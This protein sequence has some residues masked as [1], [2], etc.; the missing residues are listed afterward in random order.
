MAPLMTEQIV[1]PWVLSHV[2]ISGTA[3][4][5]SHMEILPLK[6]GLHSLNPSIIR[7]WA[8]TTPRVSLFCT[9]GSASASEAI[10]PAVWVLSHKLRASACTYWVLHIPLPILVYCEQFSV[11]CSPSALRRALK[12]M[13]TQ[14]P[15]SYRVPAMPH[16]LLK[17]PM[18]SLHWVCRKARLLSESERF[19]LPLWLP[20]LQL[21]LLI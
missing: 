19:R 1:P 3:C 8:C 18:T 17:A 10:F 16:S 9:V 11:K 13:A 14:L 2:G 21:Y 15:V 20:M 6:K 7:R 12:G 5:L 4:A